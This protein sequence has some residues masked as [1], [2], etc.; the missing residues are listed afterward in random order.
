MADLEIECCCGQLRG[1]IRNTGPRHGSRVIC[2]CRDCQAAAHHLG[3]PETLDEWGG[4]DLFITTPASMQFNTGAN[5]LACFRF[6]P[7]APRRWYAACCSTHIGNSFQNP[8]IPLISLNLACTTSRSRPV[9][10]PAGRG[11]L[12]RDAHGCPT[13]PSHII[14]MSSGVTVASLL[15]V[16]LATLRGQRGDT[17]F[18][19]DGKPVADPVML[20]RE[21]RAAALMSAGF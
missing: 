16:L 8:S 5:Q 3:H 17:P 12:V 20:S 2:Y 15:R 18:I 7:S 1:L 6:S 10:G 14:G 4:T 21:A 13:V 9:V 19:K 11:M